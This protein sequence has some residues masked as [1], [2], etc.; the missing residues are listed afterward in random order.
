MVRVLSVRLIV[1]GLPTAPTDEVL[2]SEKSR[3]AL[4]AVILPK[5]FEPVLRLTFVVAGFPLLPV[6]WKFWDS[7]V[8]PLAPVS[9][10]ELLF[11]VIFPSNV[12]ALSVT[13]AVEFS[14]V[15]F[16]AIVELSLA[17]IVAV[18][19]ARSVFPVMKEPLLSESLLFV[20]FWTLIFALIPD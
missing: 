17:V 7:K 19:F 13:V 18:V 3:A 5:R 8:D 16:P 11:C 4:V 15:R 14:D 10:S 1:E 2:L 12:E 9:V 20:P 6:I